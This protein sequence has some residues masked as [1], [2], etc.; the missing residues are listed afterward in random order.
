MGFTSHVESTYALTMFRYTCEENGRKWAID[1]WDTAGQE[2]FD[3]LHASYYYQANACIL[4]FDVT[5]KITYKNLEKWMKEIRHYCPDIPV[6]CVANKIDMD[7]SMAKKKFNLPETHKLP[8]YF[9]S[10]SDGTNVVRVFKEAI[11]L[12]IKNK[13]QPP[14]EVMDE[15]FKLLQEDDATLSKGDFYDDGI[16]PAPTPPSATPE[17]T[18]D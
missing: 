17:P 18:D 7:R 4:A 10:S 15:I 5:R 2:R 12:A 11:S 8:F 1:F 16:T 3:K 14:D 6:I 9:V 13:E